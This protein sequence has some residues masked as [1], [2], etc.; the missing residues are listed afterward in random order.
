LSHLQEKFEDTKRVVRSCKSKNRNTMAKRK[1]D[2]QWFTKHY[3][4]NL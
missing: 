2:K 4:E 1:K 3:T